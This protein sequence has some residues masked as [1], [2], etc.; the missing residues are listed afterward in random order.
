[1][2]GSGVVGVPDGALTGKEPLVIASLHTFKRMGLDGAW[3][4]ETLLGN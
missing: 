1:M 2:G 3:R 4:L